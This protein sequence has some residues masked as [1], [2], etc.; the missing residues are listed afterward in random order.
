MHVHLHMVYGCFSAI[1]KELGNCNRSCMD[2]KA[3]NIYCLT[4]HGKFAN[5]D[6]GPSDPTSGRNPPADPQGMLTGALPSRCPFLGT[7][8]AKCR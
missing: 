2:H 5:P 8:K 6:L 3:K 1:L 4:L 7:Q